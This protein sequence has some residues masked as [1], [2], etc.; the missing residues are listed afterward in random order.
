M[1][2]L[3]IVGQSCLWS[4]NYTGAAN[5]SKVPKG[6]YQS[7]TRYLL[8]DDKSI[9]VLSQNSDTSPNPTAPI[10]NAEHEIRSERPAP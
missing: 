10:A 4:G 3:A 1:L 5:G 9:V 2:C 8:V 7:A 6:D